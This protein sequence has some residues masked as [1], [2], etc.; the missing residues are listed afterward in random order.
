MS[1]PSTCHFN[2][3]IKCKYIDIFYR[4]KQVSRQC[5]LLSIKRF[6]LYYEPKGEGAG[7]LA[8]MRWHFSGSFARC[9]YLAVVSGLL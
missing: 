7:T 4:G 9:A 8:L 6:S 3:S 5:H 2:V 1:I